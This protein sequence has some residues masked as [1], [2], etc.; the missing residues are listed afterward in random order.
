LLLKRCGEICL[1]NYANFPQHAFTVVPFWPSVSRTAL[2]GRVEQSVGTLFRVQKV[3]VSNF[4]TASDCPHWCVFS[5][6]PACKCRD[7]R[8]FRLSPWCTAMR[9]IT[10]FRSTTDRICDGGPIIL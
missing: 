9:R 7:V 6:V 5:F 3:Q 4:I 10:T 8:D 2:D 1:V